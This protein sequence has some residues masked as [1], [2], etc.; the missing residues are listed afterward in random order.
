MLDLA[1]ATNFI[2]HS[3]FGHIAP[4]SQCPCSNSAVVSL[5]NQSHD[6]KLVQF[7]YQPQ[8]EKN[9]MRT[10]DHERGKEPREHLV[11]LPYLQRRRF[12][13]SNSSK[14]Q[15]MFKGKTETTI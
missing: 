5:H 7:C 2:V 13:G 15:P 1:C 3:T 8:Q 10:T 11:Q 9:H 14:S 6:L 4:Q 12:T